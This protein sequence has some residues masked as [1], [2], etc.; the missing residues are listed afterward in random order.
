[1]CADPAKALVRRNHGREPRPSSSAGEQPSGTEAP[2]LRAID[3]RGY[4]GDPVQ[5]RSASYALDADPHRVYGS[6]H[7][8]FAT[9]L[10]ILTPAD[11]QSSQI[12]PDHVRT[13]LERQWTAPCGRRHHACDRRPQQG[14]RAPRPG[15]G[16]GTPSASWSSHGCWLRVRV[17]QAPVTSAPSCGSTVWHQ[18]KRRKKEYTR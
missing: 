12:G 10:R 11:G 13:H 1:M 17:L 18:T 15:S 5:V 7:D 6:G 9:H 2:Q 8:F 14:P 4:Q 16:G 3:D